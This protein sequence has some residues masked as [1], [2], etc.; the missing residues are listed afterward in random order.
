MMKE[1]VDLEREQI[2]GPRCMLFM[3]VLGI[4]TVGVIMLLIAL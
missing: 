3:V 1:P 4:I 2:A